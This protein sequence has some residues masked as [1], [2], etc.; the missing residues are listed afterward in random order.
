[1]AEV[2]SIVRS[3]DKMW[4]GAIS[5][6]TGWKLARRREFRYLI[7]ILNIHFIMDPNKK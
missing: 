1:M 7:V 3:V 5:C 4:L 6:P 2:W